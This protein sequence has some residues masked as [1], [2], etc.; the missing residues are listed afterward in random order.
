MLFLLELRLSLAIDGIIWLTLIEAGGAGDLGWGSGL[1][2][3]DG[4]SLS[5]GGIDDED[6]CGG[7]DQAIR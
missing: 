2:A 7:G 4:W 6:L 1:S 5:G 3:R